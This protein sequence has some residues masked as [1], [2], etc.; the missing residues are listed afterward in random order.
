MRGIF[1]IKN[2]ISEKVWGYFVAEDIN[3][4][5]QEFERVIGEQKR[6]Q[7]SR[8]FTCFEPEYVWAGDNA[9]LELAKYVLPQLS[10][11]QYNMSCY[12]Q[13]NNNQIIKRIDR[14][15]DWLTEVY[16]GPEYKFL[17][18]VND[19]NRVIAI[20]LRNNTPYEEYEFSNTGKPKTR[21]IF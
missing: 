2:R 21:I 18:D 8:A 10:R 12:K 19:E 11:V 5:Q 7:R 13:I 15:L 17:I 9:E 14:S 6:Y 3:N 4:L 20:V 1:R 16:K